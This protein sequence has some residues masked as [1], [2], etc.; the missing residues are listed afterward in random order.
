[1]AHLAKLKNL[2]WSHLNETPITDAGLA[3]LANMTSLEQLDLP[4]RITDAGLPHLA[5]LANL[6]D[7]W[8]D[9]EQ[10]TEEAAAKLKRALPK[11]DV[12]LSRHYLVGPR[13][14]LRRTDDGHGEHGLPQR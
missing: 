13:P 14:K 8:I 7:V 12:R 1:M 2:R 5:G 6:E 11:G 3:H 9:G 4:F 10:I